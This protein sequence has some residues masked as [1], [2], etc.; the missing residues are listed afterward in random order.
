MEITNLVTKLLGPPEEINGGDRCPARLHRWMVIG[1]QQFKVYLQH[2]FGDASSGDLPSY[3]K[4]FISFG[5][6]ESS[7]EDTAKGLNDFPARAEWM[8]LIGKS[9]RSK[10]NTQS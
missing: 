9:S 7:L 3:P 5:L 2:T 8:V 1:N 6:A 10:K 4:R